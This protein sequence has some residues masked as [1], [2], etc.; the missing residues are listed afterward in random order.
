MDRLRTRQ[1]RWAGQKVLGGGA[2]ELRGELTAGR[3]DRS[4]VPA[5]AASFRI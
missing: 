5:T 1:A 4:Q 3:P 2:I